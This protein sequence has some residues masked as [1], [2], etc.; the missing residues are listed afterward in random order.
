[1]SKKAAVMVG[2]IAALTAAAVLG[3]YGMRSGGFPAGTV[4]AE[5]AA[6]AASDEELTSGTEETLTGTIL[7]DTIRYSRPEEESTYGRTGVQD[8]IDFST[9]AHRTTDES[10]PVVYFTD[11]ISPVGLINIYN[12]LHVTPQGNV[13]VKVSSGEAGNNHF[14]NPNL[15]KNLIREVNGTI[16]ECNTLDYGGVRASTAMHYQV[17]EDHGWTD[18]ADFDIMDETGT[19]RI[20]VNGGTYLTE[21]VVGANLQNYDFVMVLSHFKGHGMGGF[22]GALKNISIG[23]AAPEG[24]NLIHTAGNV[25]VGFGN[26]SQEAFTASMAEAAKAVYEYEGN[27]SKMLFINVMNNLSVDCDC[28][29]NPTAPSMANVGILA[30]TDPVALDQACVDI[31]Y[32]APD[33]GDIAA[34]M[35]QLMGVH[36]LEHAEEIG[37]GSRTYRMD[38]M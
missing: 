1:M 5:E 3:E 38:I 15:V 16:V 21:D 36:I 23:I 12:A 19:M 28:V 10:A 37:F 29:G 14:L 9:L 11:D 22:G 4:R 25:S 6:P 13:A 20:P 26:A 31:V 27:G 8:W 24:K 33:G 30:S 7:S 18:V 2:V 35:E 17:A 32:A 34:R